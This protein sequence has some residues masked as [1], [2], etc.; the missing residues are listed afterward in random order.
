M[1]IKILSDL[2]LSG[3]NIFT[4]KYVSCI[5]LLIITGFLIKSFKNIDQ[6]LSF[7]VM[8]LEFIVRSRF[9]NK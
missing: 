2:M 5:I 9:F 1:I 3:W 4:A 8:A 6:F 7:I